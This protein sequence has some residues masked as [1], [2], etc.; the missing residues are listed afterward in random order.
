MSAWY[1]RHPLPWKT[2]KGHWAREVRDAAGDAVAWCG[3]S[4]GAADARTIVRL[5]NAAYTRRSVG[6]AP[7]RRARGELP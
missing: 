2:G 1:Y 5:A 4:T 3:G 7:R 6:K